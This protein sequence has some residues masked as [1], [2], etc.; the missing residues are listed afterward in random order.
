MAP[1]APPGYAYFAYGFCFG[2]AVKQ[3]IS[4]QIAITQ[5]VIL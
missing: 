1:L 4:R 3:F 2:I 5:V